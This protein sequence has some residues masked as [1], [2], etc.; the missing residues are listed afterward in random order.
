MALQ[1]VRPLAEHALL[2]RERL[3]LP[4]LRTLPIGGLRVRQGAVPEALAVSEGMP[5]EAGEAP[6]HPRRSDAL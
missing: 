3:Q 1:V 6:A 5:G 4:A 2:F